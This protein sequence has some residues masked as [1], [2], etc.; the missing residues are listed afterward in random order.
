MT[1][2]TLGM[3]ASVGDSACT[4]LAMTTSPDMSSK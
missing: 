4:M 2:A 3:S 1:R